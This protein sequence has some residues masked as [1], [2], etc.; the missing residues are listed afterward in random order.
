[1]KLKWWQYLLWWKREKY[2]EEKE[3]QKLQSA[4]DRFDLKKKQQI[5]NIEVSEES[6]DIVLGIRDIPKRPPT[7]RCVCLCLSCI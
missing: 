5:E 6:Y 3:K 4:A 1:M 2:M 7:K